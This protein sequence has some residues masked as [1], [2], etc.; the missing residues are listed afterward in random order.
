[1]KIKEAHKFKYIVHT[2]VHMDAFE[3]NT[4]AYVVL[5]SH[6]HVHGQLWAYIVLLL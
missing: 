1:M 3:C 2:Y 4:F 6:A 5:Q